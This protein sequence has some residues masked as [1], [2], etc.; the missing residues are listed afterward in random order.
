MFSKQENFQ[1]TKV[2]I[3]HHI[4]DDP[5]QVKNTLYLNMK[6]INHI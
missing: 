2:F 6:L 1:F 5:D 3:I 4:S